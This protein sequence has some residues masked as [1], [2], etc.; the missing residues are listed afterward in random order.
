MSCGDD[1]QTGGTSREQELQGDLQTQHPPLGKAG[2]VPPKYEGDVL[3]GR[4]WSLP[5]KSKEGEA[6]A[7]D[8]WENEAYFMV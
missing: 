6:I 4:G 7:W 3:T 2:E 8:P 5:H 1:R